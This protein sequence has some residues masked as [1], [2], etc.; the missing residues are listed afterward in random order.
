MLYMVL[1]DNERRLAMTRAL[2]SMGTTLRI[3]RI[4]LF[5]RVVLKCSSP[6]AR[7]PILM[8]P[9]R[10]MS[11]VL[12]LWVP[13]KRCLGL[14]Q[15]GLSQ[16]WQTI[17]PLGIGPWCISHETR[18]ARKCTVVDPFGFLLM[19]AYPIRVFDPLHP[20][21]SSSPNLMTSSSYLSLTGTFLNLYQH[22][23]EQ[24]FPVCL[25]CRI[26]NFF[27]QTVHFSVWPRC[28]V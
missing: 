16:W 12:S 22:S 1:T 9:F 5:L 11:C 4:F 8:R 15:V 6:L 24:N 20:Q 19:M 18:W 21:Q 28:L 13:T 10:I 14:E 17:L 27:L 7:L 2:T 25:S 3:K 23:N 26:T